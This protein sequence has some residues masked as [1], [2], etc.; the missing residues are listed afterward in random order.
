MRIFIG[1]ILL[2]V[3]FV[4]LTTHMVMKKGWKTTIKIWVAALTLTACIYVGGYLVSGS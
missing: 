1:S 4:F 2:S 3:P